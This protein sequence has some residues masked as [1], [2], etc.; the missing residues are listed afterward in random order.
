MAQPGDKDGV[1]NI[2]DGLFVGDPRCPLA[3]SIQT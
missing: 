1:F 3:L 2:A